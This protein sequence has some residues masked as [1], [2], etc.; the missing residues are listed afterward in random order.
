MCC[1][2]TEALVFVLNGG[3]SNGLLYM[4]GVSMQ[5]ILNLSGVV[6]EHYGK[7]GQFMHYLSLWT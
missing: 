1:I 7:N 3:S 5:Y 4:L 6:Y 2:D